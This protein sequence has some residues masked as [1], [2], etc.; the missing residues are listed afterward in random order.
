MSEE[1]R[2]FVRIAIY[3]TIAGTVY[4]FL[5]YEDAGTALFGFLIA[6]CLFVAITVGL[7]IRPARSERLSSGG[8]LTTLDRLIGFRDHPADERGSPLEVEPEAI[9]PASSW[10]LFAAAA[11]LLI[12]LGLLYGAWF[13]LP[14]LGLAAA[15][16][17]GWTTELTR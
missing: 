11:F 17:W 3:A 2:F 8:P 10:P 14:G 4:W 13:W 7:M 6:G 12:G 15:A 1:P 16:A 9:A 5:S